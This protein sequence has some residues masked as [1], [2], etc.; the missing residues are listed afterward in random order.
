MFTTLTAFVIIY[1]LIST[2]LVLLILKPYIRQFTNFLKEICGYIG[3]VIVIFA[4]TLLLIAIEIMISIK[5]VNV[6]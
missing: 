3:S 5:I 6:F 2:M 4:L 1:V